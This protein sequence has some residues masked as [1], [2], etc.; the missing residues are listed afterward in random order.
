M[1]RTPT[2][3]YGILGI[4]ASD[5]E[6]IAVYPELSSTV[7]PHSQEIRLFR[8][9]SLDIAV[10]IQNDGD[11]P[12][13][14]TLS[15]SVLRFAARQSVGSVP[16]SLRNKVILGNESALILKT[17]YDPDQIEI[18]NDV[19]GKAII[20]IQRDDTHLLPLG[21]ARWDLEVVKATESI[22]LPTGNV[23]FS[24]GSNVVMSIS[25]ELNWTELHIRPG[26]L[27]QAQGSTVLVLEVLS[28]QHLKLDW[29]D[30][31]AETLPTN[32]A[33]ACCDAVCMYRS[34]TKT[35]AYGA[36]SILG[37]VVR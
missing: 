23:L 35:V 8:G 36:L 16:T 34:S 31:T 7:L 21:S 14:V 13:T 12:D 26:D 30:W 32:N 33:S 20:H 3:N 4:V 5:P 17:S 11:P 15:N 9:D 18:T 28:A 37:D 29:S 22:S 25:P 27:F 2:T 19:T 1:D 6:V 24:A 10:Q